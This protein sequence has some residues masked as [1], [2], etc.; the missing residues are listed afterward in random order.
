MGDILIFGK[1]FQEH[2]QDLDDV[3]HTLRAAN[4]SQPNQMPLR[5]FQGHI[6]SDISIHVDPKKTKLS[7]HFLPLRL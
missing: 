2:L 6:I 1:S 3:F 5:K 7:A 4:P